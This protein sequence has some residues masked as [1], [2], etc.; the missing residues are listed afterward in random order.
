[1]RQRFEGKVALVT[2]AGAGIGRAIALRFAE[3]GARVFA[4]GRS[5]SVEATAA[6]HDGITPFLADIGDEG[7]IDAAFAACRAQIGI[8]T[9]VCLS[10]IHI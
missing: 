5:A 9:L 7:Q 8:P 10:L 3:E 2:G 1:M 4:V 6:M